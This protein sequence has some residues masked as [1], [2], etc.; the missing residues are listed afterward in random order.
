LIPALQQQKHVPDE[1]IIVLDRCTDDSLDIMKAFETKYANVSTIVIDHIP[2]HFSPKK[3]ALTLGIKK[4]RNECVL[5]M[6]ADC[7][8]ATVEWSSHMSQK[9]ELGIDFVLGVS[10]LLTPRTLLGKYISFET[11]TSSLYYITTSLLFNPVMAVGRNLAIRRSY[12]LSINGYNKF[13]HINGGD[14]DLLI[15]HFASQANCAVSISPAAHTYSRSKSNLKD[16]LQQKHR[17]HAVNK[18]YKRSKKISY[19]ISWSAQI[20]LWVSFVILATQHTVG[21]WPL[22]ILLGYFLI[23]GSTYQLVSRSMDKGF[24]VYLLPIME[25]MHLFIIPAIVFGSRINKEVKWK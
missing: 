23:K 25:L 13:Q 3:Y 4:A 12:F 2:D 16:Y 1:I 7:L 21:F 5:L 8:P 24:S 14:D 19:I 9:L 18:H 15:Q 10:P 22:L 11:F 17:H 20:S 6:D